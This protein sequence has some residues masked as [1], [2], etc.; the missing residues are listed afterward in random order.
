MTK[1]LIC[2]RKLTSEKSIISGI[3]SGCRNQ[4]KGRRSKIFRTIA[5]E[6][7]E[8]VTIGKQVWEKSGN[9]WINTWN[10][11]TKSSNI[12][13]EDFKKYLRRYDMIIKV[14]DISETLWQSILD[15]TFDMTKFEETDNEE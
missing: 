13:H 11:G 2:G 5:F 12:E 14:E 10:G 9:F 8:T 15:G 1:C 3:G 6:K 7:G 4:K